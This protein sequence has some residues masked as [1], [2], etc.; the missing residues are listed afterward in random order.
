MR[1]RLPI[2]RRM[3]E[4]A[5][6]DGVHGLAEVEME[7]LPGPPRWRWNAVAATAPAMS[8]TPM[9]APSRWAAGTIG[10]CSVERDGAPGLCPGQVRQRR[11][12][13]S[14]AGDGSKFVHVS[15]VVPSDTGIMTLIGRTTESV[16]TEKW[17][18]KAVTARGPRS[19]VAV[20][21]GRSVGQR[22]DVAALG[23]GDDHAGQLVHRDRRATA[24]RAPA[25]PSRAPRAPTAPAA[26]ARRGV[27][28]PPGDG[29]HAARTPWRRASTAGRPRGAVGP[30]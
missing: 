18:S 15:P 14:R 10:S 2:Q 6:I 17:Q 1:G 8:G 25:P 28:P 11:A 30:G 22:L 21:A 20:R 5:R 12:G 16:G 29:W 24:R 3:P 26:H 23:D 27:Q 4:G 19:G 7:V 9:Q 13:R